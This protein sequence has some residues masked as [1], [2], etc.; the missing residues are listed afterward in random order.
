ME[1]PYRFAL[2]GTLKNGN[3][4]LCIEVMSNLAYGERDIFSTYLP[5]PPMGLMEE[6]YIIS[7]SI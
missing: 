2:T 4:R 3:N 5:L 1:R 7:S 6:V